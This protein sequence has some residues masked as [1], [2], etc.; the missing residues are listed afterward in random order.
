MLPAID[1]LEAA[2]T[3]PYLIDPGPVIDGELFDRQISEVFAQGK[4]SK[5]PML[6]GFTADEGTFYYFE[7]EGA[8]SASVP[9][10][11]KKYRQSVRLRYRELSD[12]YLKVYPDSDLYKATVSPIRDAIFGWAAIYLAKNHS[13]LIPDTYMYYFDHSP[14][15]QSKISGEH[16]IFLM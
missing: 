8:F 3:I 1:I 7:G 16:S 4:Q 11:K 6:V 9:E 2:E 15:G 12:Q 13:Q 14:L 10:S 5:V